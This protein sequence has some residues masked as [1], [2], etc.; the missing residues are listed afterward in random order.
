[1][2]GPTHGDRA[3]L[4]TKT[5]KRNGFDTIEIDLVKYS[6]VLHPPFDEDL[7]I[8]LN[9]S[10]LWICSYHP[11]VRQSLQKLHMVQK[12]YRPEKIYLVQTMQIEQCCVH[13]NL[14]SLVKV[15]VDRLLT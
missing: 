1:M 9:M 8:Q 7:D 12:V 10:A 4:T 13:Q 11:I 5:S 2:V 3:Y 14:E 15:F 6:F